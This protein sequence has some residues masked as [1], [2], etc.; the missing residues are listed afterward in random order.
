MS[1]PAFAWSVRFF[2]LIALSEFV[3]LILGI[4]P[5][6]TSWAIPVFFGTLFCAVLGVV[7]VGLIGI[8]KRYLGEGGALI[9]RRRIFERAWLISAA[10]T[11]L[12]FLQYYRALAWWTAGLVIALLLLIELTLRQRKT[13]L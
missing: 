10:V 2:L 9:W 4:D 13:L 3:R 12:V 8:Y 6:R 1:F 7:G 11:S 5:N